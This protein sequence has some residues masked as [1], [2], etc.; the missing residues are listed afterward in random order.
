MSVVWVDHYAHTGN[1]WYSGDEL[2]ELGE[3]E[4]FTVGWVVAKNTKAI[5]IAGHIGP[6]KGN[7]HYS[8]V[9]AI[10]TRALVSWEPLPLPGVQTLEG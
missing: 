4:C 3:L 10:A 6:Q 1:A 7:T 9:M 8:G 5:K 2:Q